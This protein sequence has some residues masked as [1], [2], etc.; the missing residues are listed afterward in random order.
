[1]SKHYPM[2]R[3]HL[4]SCRHEAAHAILIEHFGGSFR[5][6]HAPLLSAR[7]GRGAGY[8]EYSN[9]RKL[10]PVQFSCVMM[11]GSVAEHLWHGSP[12]GLVSAHDLADMQ[13]AGLK[14]EDFRIIW[15][16]TERIVRKLKP[17]IWQLAAQ[18]RSG[19]RLRRPRGAPKRRARK[20]AKRRSDR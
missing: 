4:A 1:M 14:G 17:E 12:R 11:A 19:E 9:V 20:A 7:V 13:R 18:L 8:V 5:S 16:E 3:T 2:A 6:A 10:G 15:Q